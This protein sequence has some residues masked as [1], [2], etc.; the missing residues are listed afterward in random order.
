MRPNT[1]YSHRALISA[2]VYAIYP[3]SQQEAADDAVAQVIAVAPAHPAAVAMEYRQEQ[4]CYFPLG[5]RSQAQPHLL[6]EGVLQ[7]LASLAAGERVICQLLLAPADWSWNHLGRRARP[8]ARA[9]D[10]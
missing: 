1:T 4:L 2:L 3:G 8:A 7:L 5:L 9:R 10:Q 6:S